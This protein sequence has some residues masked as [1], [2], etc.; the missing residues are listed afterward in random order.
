MTSSHLQYRR[1][2]GVFVLGAL[3]PAESTACE[4]HL[5]D[6]SPCTREAE[7]LS[8]VA[9]L[10]AELA[11]A[12][13]DIATSLSGMSTGSPGPAVRGAPAPRRRARQAFGLAAS[14]ALF[15]GGVAAGVGF[16]AEDA[17]GTDPHQ[18]HT[19]ASRLVMVGEVH[20]GANATT[21]VSAAV[22]LEDKKWGTHV[23][24]EVK[25][26]KGPLD[27]S[28]VAVTRTGARQ[29]VTTWLV[30]AP[31]YGVPGQPE[32]LLVHG[33][34]ALKR[35]AIERFEIVDQRGNALVAMDV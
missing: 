26:V 4:A 27:C 14:V 32:A 28:L 20:R 35:D 24:L 31:G 17:S 5:L 9:V 16:Q 2:L 11:R 19:S 33:A 22:G 13:P 34:A 25:G 15:L 6:C 18:D 23:A 21:G 3:D 29:T 8:R 30:P 1:G 10:L 7:E 12:E